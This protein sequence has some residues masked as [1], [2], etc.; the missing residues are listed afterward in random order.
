MAHKSSV[1]RICDE[2]GNF[3][4]DDNGAFASKDTPP[5]PR[6]DTKTW[7]P[8]DNRGQ[9][10]HAQL[11]FEKIQAS[12]SDINTLLN[13]WAADKIALGLN[14]SLFSSADELYEKIDAI[15]KGECTWYTFGVRWN[16]EL[17]ENS[18]GWKHDTYLIHTRDPLQVAANL[19]NNTDFD[20]R[21]EYVPYE[22]YTS[23]HKR[24]FSNLMSARKAWKDSVCPPPFRN[25]L[26]SSSISRTA[27]YAK[28][29]MLSTPCSS[30]Q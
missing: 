22:E 10:E 18:K 1:A 11:L 29:R 4:R 12:Y 30:R 16:G 23:P 20:G 25:V 26:F 28:T 27:S 9:Y 6:D 24:R 15:R 17:D 3:L 8:F 21:W 13:L 2:N 5:P 14:N 7:E 19:T